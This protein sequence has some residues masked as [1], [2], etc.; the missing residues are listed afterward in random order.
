MGS[1]HVSV[2]L[3]DP[4]SNLPR[5]ELEYD[6][7]PYLEQLK[8]KVE[9]KKTQPGKRKREISAAEELEAGAIGGK[10]KRYE[11]GLSD[12]VLRST[13]R[14]ESVSPPKKKEE[15]VS[16]SKDKKIKEK[17]VKEN[18]KKSESKEKKSEAKGKG[19][20]RSRSESKQTKSKKASKK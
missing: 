6:I 8:L 10:R 18:E 11:V 13:T 12:R 3:S 14:K 16:K 5:P 20:S 19:K 15:A 4:S 2:A 7:V 9:E 17:S 1:Q